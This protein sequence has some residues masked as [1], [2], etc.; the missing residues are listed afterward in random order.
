ME[1]RGYHYYCSTCRTKL[2]KRG[3]TAKGTQRWKCPKCSRSAVKPRRD[4]SRAL[5]LE[6]F[7]KWL[8][9][10]QSQ[11]ELKV[12][13]R[14]WRDRIAWCWD[15]VPRPELT[16]EIFEIIL[17]DGIRI[18][19]LVNLIARTPQAVINWHWAGWESSYTWEDLLKQLPAPAVVVCDGQKG[20]LLAIA[21]CWPNTRIQRCIFHVW[22]NIRA[23]LSLHPKTEA[24]RQLLGLVKVLLKGIYTKK[25]A[26]IWQAQLAAWEKR[27]GHL[28]RER[29]YVINPGPGQRKYWYTHGRL[30][31]A[32]NQL[33][34][35]LKANQLFTYLETNLTEQPIPRMTNYLEG[36]I[37]SQIRTRLKNHRGLNQVHAQ[38]LTDWY[39]YSRT[40]DPKPPRNCL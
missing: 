36:G 30:R 6:R 4:L 35:L 38:R 15:I 27:H 12:S 39:L 20:V 32:Y 26:L 21:R 5:L 24:G 2:Q 40:N 29:T 17:L 7:V 3:L 16:G 23:K 9:G 22:Q 34:K 18:C 1:K 13:D 19:N 33:D 10:K 37:N 31:S 11:S 8:L 25:E 14:T 28:I